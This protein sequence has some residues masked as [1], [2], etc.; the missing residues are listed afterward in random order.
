MQQYS[1]S[2]RR[3]GDQHYFTDGME[4]IFSSMKHLL[5]HLDEILCFKSTNIFYARLLW[6]WLNAIV[7]ELPAK[8][9]ANIQF[10]NIF[11]PSKCQTRQRSDV[12]AQDE[13]IFCIHSQRASTVTCVQSHIH[14]QSVATERASLRRRNSKTSQ[15]RY[16]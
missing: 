10:L 13:K 8:H 2:E 9:Q 14:T 7:S 16:Y 6:F 3:R 12:N 15:L 1:G 5:N 4:I 11:P